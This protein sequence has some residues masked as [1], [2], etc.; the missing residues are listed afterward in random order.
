MSLENLLAEIRDDLR[1][2]PMMLRIQPGVPESLNEFPAVIVAA[3][4]GRCWLA[5]HGRATGESPLQCEHDIRV[6][7]HVPRKHLE[8][9]AATMT[10]IA[11]AATIFLYSGFVRDRYNSTMV[12]T[13]NPR[14]ANNATSPIDYTIGPSNWAGQQTYAFLCDFKVTTEQEVA[15]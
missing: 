12:V 10:A 1:D 13:G 4:R 9:D 5:S 3:M 11:D 14:T 2:M 7:I 6:E 8:T 15:P